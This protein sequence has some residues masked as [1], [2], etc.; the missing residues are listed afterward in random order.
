MADPWKLTPGTITLTES[1]TEKHQVHLVNILR[2]GDGATISGEEMMRRGKEAN[3]IPMLWFL[4]KLLVVAQSNALNAE[5]LDAMPLHWCLEGLCIILPAIMFRENDRAGYVFGLREVGT[6]HEWALQLYSLE[7]ETFGPSCRFL[8]TGPSP[9]A[10]D[11]V[12]E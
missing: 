9:V 5:N 10:E 12:G 11:P 1:P 2:D 8:K 3:A 4:K 7:D 6:E